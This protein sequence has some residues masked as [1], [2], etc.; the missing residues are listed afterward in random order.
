MSQHFWCAQICPDGCCMLLILTWRFP[1]KVRSMEVPKNGWFLVENP[2]WFWM[3]TGGIPISGNLHMLLLQHQRHVTASVR[4][5]ITSKQLTRSSSTGCRTA[6]FQPNQLRFND[7][8]V[9]LKLTRNDTEWHHEFIDCWLVQGNFFC[10]P[11]CAMKYTVPSG[12]LT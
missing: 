1:N 9:R 2:T 10:K 3:M 7:A 6:E 5:R 4:L 11:W 8:M 12:N